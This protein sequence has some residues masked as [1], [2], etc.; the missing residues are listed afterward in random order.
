MTQK[1]FKNEGRAGDVLANTEEGMKKDNNQPGF[2][3]R[4]CNALIAR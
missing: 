4:K 3:G 2:F 1:K